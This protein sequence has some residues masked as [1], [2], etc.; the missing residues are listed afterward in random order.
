MLWKI[1]WSKKKFFVESLSVNNTGD[2]P[3][4][5]A[6]SISATCSKC[7]ITK[8]RLGWSDCVSRYTRVGAL[9]TAESIFPLCLT[10]FSLH[11]FGP[12][13]YNC[14][15][16]FWPVFYSPVCTLIQFDLYTRLAS[17][18]ARGFFM[19]FSVKDIFLLFHQILEMYFSLWCNVYKISHFQENKHNSVALWILSKM[20]SSTPQ[21]YHTFEL[22]TTIPFNGKIPISLN[23]CFINYHS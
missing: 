18:Y 6:Y 17:F 19:D 12:F 10:F 5:R 7:I 9:V 22:R 3:S 11:A 20:T 21:T 23:R 1:N 16:D 14:E 15:L 2:T 4:D 8:T 13:F